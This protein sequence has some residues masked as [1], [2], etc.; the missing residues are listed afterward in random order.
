MK[1]RIVRSSLYLMSLFFLNACV[2]NLPR[3]DTSPAPGDISSIPLHKVHNKPT[4]K[5]QTYYDP[6]HGN[7]SIYDTY[8]H[9]NDRLGPYFKVKD[10]SKTGD[11]GFRYARIDKSIVNCLSRVRATLDKP[12]SI[13]SSYR[14]WDYNNQLIKEGQ[15]AS[16]TSYH[17]SGKAADVA[18]PGVSVT[19]FVTTV[20]SRCGCG[21]AIGVGNGWFHVDT[22]GHSTR[23]WGYG[24]L[25]TVKRNVARKIHKK[26]CGKNARVASSQ[27]N[28]N[29]SSEFFTGVSDTIKSVGQDLKALF[30]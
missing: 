9:G 4:S 21:T 22:R 13:N 25:S 18:M 7:V 29:E 10:F 12:I 2:G 28:D 3:I 11:I 30:K 8:Q 27:K 15:K 20:Y 17:M 6:R 5:G 23:P 1:Q 14:H 24:G 26:M 16:K 19:R